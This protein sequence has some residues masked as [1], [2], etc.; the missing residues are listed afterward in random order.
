MSQQKAQN[1]ILRE[2]L[3]F[4]AFLDFLVSEMA[5]RFSEQNRGPVI[6]F[7]PLIPKIAVRS[8]AAKH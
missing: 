3:Q 1:S 8:K 7:F 5:T 4:L 6:G 2:A